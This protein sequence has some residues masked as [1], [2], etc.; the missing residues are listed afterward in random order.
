MDSD[1]EE[2]CPLCCT[3]LDVTDRAIQYCECGCESRGARQTGARSRLPQQRAAAAAAAAPPPPATSARC[4][5]RYCA[6]FLLLLTHGA[7]LAHSRRF[8]QT[9]CAYSA[10]T[11][12]WTRRPRR[13]WRPSA[14]TAG[15]STMRRRSRCST[16]TRSSEWLVGCF[17]VGNA[18]A[19]S[20][21]VCLLRW[22]HAWAATVAA[23]ASY[24][25]LRPPPAAPSLLLPA[26]VVCRSSG[27]RSRSAS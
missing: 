4:L 25:S 1:D 26:R 18:Q 7:V 12:S 9:R 27:W 13:A 8:L 10:T 5:W 2:L 23:A 6:A 17:A 3:E 11:R 16:L 14:Q 19:G 21:P 22:Y 15:P 24:S 20:E